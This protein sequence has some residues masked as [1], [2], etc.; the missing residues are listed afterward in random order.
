MFQI[1]IELFLLPMIPLPM[2][3]NIMKQIYLLID[4]KP[5]LESFLDVHNSNAYKIIVDLLKNVQD[6]RL[7]FY[8]K[9]I[10]KKIHL[11]ETLDSIR[12]SVAQ[13][14]SENLENPPN[15]IGS[16]ES[17]ENLFK[18]LLEM[19]KSD[20]ILFSQ[21]KRFLPI[22]AQFEINQE[23]HGKRDFVAYY[24]IHNFLESLM[25]LLSVKFALSPTLY[26]S[27]LE[28]IKLMMSNP[29]ELN[30]FC[31]NI[32]LLNVITKLLLQ[33]STDEEIAANLES[34]ENIEIGFEIAYKVSF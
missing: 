23:T 25:L 34:F 13:Y 11:Y 5:G 16:P 31:S 33:P 3:L 29:V 9:S 4:T 18:N 30:Y 26:G 15:Q 19:L 14:Y 6:I 22:T 10:L 20:E 7:M 32:E 2:K 12:K 8:I 24:K 28:C 17:I 1:L 27:V 21:P